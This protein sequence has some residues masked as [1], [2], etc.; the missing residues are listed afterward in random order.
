MYFLITVSTKFP[1]CNNCWNSV[2]VTQFLILIT[3]SKWKCSFCTCVVITPPHGAG[4]HGQT[5]KPMFLEGGMQM[6]AS[7]LWGTLHLNASYKKLMDWK[8]K[9]IKQTGS[10]PQ[11]VWEA[12]VSN[13][14]DYIIG[15]QYYM[16][17]E[18]MNKK[19]SL[20]VKKKFPQSSCIKC[21][22]VYLFSIHYL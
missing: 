6:Q 16:L 10:S 18:W 20:M 15:A 12:L 7:V 4:L 17:N 9:I 2:V 8:F 19:V 5:H 13:T 1:I 11:M 3:T 14:A 21:E 22:T